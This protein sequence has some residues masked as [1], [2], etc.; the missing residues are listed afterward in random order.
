MIVV[1]DKNTKVIKSVLG[2]IPKEMPAELA[3]L[4]LEGTPKDFCSCRYVDT[5]KVKPRQ[6]VT[7]KSAEACLPC[8][9]RLKVEPTSV[10]KIL[11]ETITFGVRLVDKNGQTISSSMSFTLEIWFGRN[12]IDSRSYQ[13][14]TGVTSGKTYKIPASY[15]DSPTPD[16]NKKI[17][18][19][20]HL[21]AVP[22]DELTLAKNATVGVQEN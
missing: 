12:L 13:L 9:G 11:G 2:G 8:C 20:V 14:S 7:Q 15:P 1:Y 17:P 5:A 16:G 21:I 3:W 4:R 6:T 10:K 18:V 19:N 22:P